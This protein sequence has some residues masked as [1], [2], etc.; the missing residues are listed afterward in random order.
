MT[1]LDFEILFFSVTVA[2]EQEFSHYKHWLSIPSC[3]FS[4]FLISQLDWEWDFCSKVRVCA[5]ANISFKDFQDKYLPQK[6]CTAPG[7]WPKSLN[8]HN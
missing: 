2:T 5:I 7:T 1:G 6:S 3:F 8:I 4:F